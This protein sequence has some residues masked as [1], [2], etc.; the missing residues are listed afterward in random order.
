[1]RRR[2][3]PKTSARHQPQRTVERAE[4]AVQFVAAAQDVSGRRDHAVG[5]LPALQPRILLDAIE[6]HFGGVAENRKHRA[7]F[8][9]IDGVI[10]P[11][12]GGDFAPIE[13][14]NAI[15]LAPGECHLAGGDG[16]AQKFAPTPGHPIAFDAMGAPQL[17]WFDFADIHPAPPWAVGCGLWA[18][19]ALSS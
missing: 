15:E 4:H 6:R 9:E 3:P 11:L 2:L 8:E 1:M 16:C 7:V 19:V 10:A 14:E 5:A 13:T 18:V 17:A 12:A